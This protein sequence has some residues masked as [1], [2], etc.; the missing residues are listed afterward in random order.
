MSVPASAVAASVARAE[1]TDRTVDVPVRPGQGVPKQQG[2]PTMTKAP[3]T[4]WPE[5]VRAR[6]DLTEAP[7]GDPLAVAP[8]GAVVDTDRKSGAADSAVVAVQ[9]ATA[10]QVVKAGTPPQGEFATSPKET[11]G[12]GALPKTGGPAVRSG[13]RPTRVDVEV[14]DRA[15]VKPVGGV[16]LGLK[17]TRTDGSA[18]PGPVRV[19]VDYSGFRY[20][21]GGDFA[22]RLR[23]VQLPACAL[24]TPRKKGC[25]PD[26]RR[27]VDVDNDER[28]GTLSATVFADADPDAVATEKSGPMLGTYAAT[29]AS[30][31]TVLA[32]TTGSSSDEGD[33]RATTLNPAGSWDVSIGSGA[34]TYEMPFKLPKAPTGSTPSLALTY[35]SQSVDGRTS[36]TNNQASWAG[37]G[38]DLQ[39]G[40]IERRYK[41]CTQDG[42]PT[43]GDMCW[44]S[45]NSGTEPDGAVYVIN[46]NGITSQLIQDGNGTGSYHV[47]DDPGWRV[48]HLWGGHGS[49]DEY[50]VISS[51][52]GMRYYFGWGRSE[53]TDGATDSVLTIPVVGNDTGE[54]CHAQFPEPCAQAWRWNL[55]RVVDPNEVENAYFYDRQTNH[56]RSVANTDKAR[57]YDAGSY[58]TRIEYGWASQITGAQ[59]PAKVEL[60]H[61]G[62]CVERMTEKD[63]LTTEPAACPPIS[64]TPDSY[65]DVPTD[66]MCDGTSGDSYCAGKTYYPTF[67]T[68]DMLWDVKTYVRDNDAAAWDPAMQYQMKYGLPN[69]DGTVGKTL[70]LDYIQRKGYGDGPDLRLPVINFNGEW[71]DNQVGSSLLN[72]RRVTKVYGDLGGVTSVTYGQ[73]DACD[74][75]SLPSQSSNTQPCF[76]QKWTPEGETENRT[77]WFKKYVVT[78]VS[79]DPGVGQGPD[80]DGDPDMTTRYEYNGGAGWRFTNDPLSKDEDETWSDWRGYQQVEVF[81]GTKDN[82]ASTYHWLYRGLD[83]DRTSKT[84]P[85]LTRSVKVKDGFGTEWTDSAWLAGKTLETSKRDG[86]GSSHERVLKEYWVHNTAQYDGLPDARFVRESKTST[87]QRTSTG[88]R[89][90]TVKDEYDSTSSTSTTYG[91][92]LRTNDWGLEDHGDN[93]CTTYGRTYSTAAFPDSDVKRWMVLEDEQRHYAADCADRAAANQ[94]AYTVT[95]YDG[96]TSVTDND[97]KLSDGNPTEKRVHT[98]AA[99]FR[100]TKYEYD[101]AGRVTAAVDGK[102]NRTTTTY[103]PATSW[104]VDGVKVTTPDPD[105]T[106]PGTAMSTT[107]W[108]SRLWGTPYRVV[109][110]NGRSTRIVHDSVGRFSTVFKPTEAANY[111]DG[112]PSVEFTYTLPTTTNADGVPDTVSGPPRI[113][114]AT[115]QSGSTYVTSYEYLD[116]QGRTRETQATAPEGT[117]RTVVST[118]YD[119]SGNV[120][121]TSAAFYNSGAAG[122][123]MVLPTVADLPSYSDPIIDWAGREKEL[124]TLVNGVAQPGGRVRTYYFGDH[125]TVV[126]ATGERTD[127]YTDVFGQITKVVEHGPT[128]PSD[129]SYAYTRSGHLQKITDAKGNTTTYTYNWLGERTATDDPDAGPS[130]SA[131][132]DN[133]QTVTTT[134]ANGAT[135]TYQYDALQ[136]LTAVTEGTTTLSRLTYDSA[137]GGA[138][139]LASATTYADGKAY[140]VAITGYD[141][142]GRMTGKKYTVPDDGSGLTGSYAFGYG[143]DLADHVTSVTYPAAGGLPAETVTTAY[144]AQGQPQKVSSPLATYQS[145]IGFDRL[146]RLNARTFGAGGSDAVVNRA[147]SFDDANGSGALANIKTTVTAGGTTKVAQ[148]DSFTRDLG[149]QIT[150]VR[151][152]VTQQSECFTYDEL[153]RLTRAWTTGA[154]DGCTGAATPDLAGGPDPYDTGYT[155]DELGNLRSVTDRTGS[156]TTTKDYTYPG[157]GADG[158]GYTPNQPRP[159]AVTRAGA[160]TFAYDDAGR[161]TSRTVDG[162][163]STLEWNAQKR[164]SRVTQHKATGDEVSRYV[165]DTEGNVLLRTSAA[166][167]VFYLDGQELHATG[168]TVR[169]TRQYS[170]AGTAVALREADGS[171]GGKLTWLL[172]DTQA[173]TSLLVTMGGIVTRR[174]YSPFGKERGTGGALPAAT[175]RGFLGAPEDDATGLSI[176]GARMYDAELG[177]FISPDE[178][179]QPYVPQQMNAYSYT[180]NNPVNFSD[181]TGLADGRACRCGSRPVLKPNQPA[182]DGGGTPGARGDLGTNVQHGCDQS[183]LNALDSLVN[184]W[185][186]QNINKRLAIELRTYVK[187]LGGNID[188]CIPGADV[189]SGAAA[190]C[191]DKQGYTSDVVWQDVLNEWLSGRGNVLAFGIGSKVT[192]QLATGPHNTRLLQQIRERIVDADYDIA[193]GKLG[194]DAAYVDGQGMG[195]LAEFPKDILGMLTD[196]RQGKGTPDAF[197]GSFNEVYQVLNVDKKNRQFTVGFAAFN[198]TGTASLTHLLPDIGQGNQMASVHQTYYWTVTV[199]E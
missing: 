123:G 71:K 83:G 3:R 116:G 64:T 196:G 12:S 29:T 138:G 162:V 104:P 160:D 137:P 27:F 11:Q 195:K 171:A 77:G 141:G 91:L 20:A 127:T 55:D 56:Y 152:G 99:Q 131:Y 128:G 30:E 101:G 65:P 84:D 86:A 134:N 186:K 153:N 18:A 143:Y 187:I 114:T 34:F 157:Y 103:S 115:L 31:P 161:M 16:G 67:F 69:P 78:E 14:L 92:P 140:T 89:V 96:A 85:S 108:S 192:Q 79:V 177:R 149:G 50:W 15:A 156:G 142:R 36:A 28:S 197:L 194:G 113:T 110:P 191:L 48:Q 88:W 51:Q 68:T 185:Q 19:T 45:P 136:R 130:T 159:H 72:F 168:G 22:S 118:R 174:R 106:G 167:S 41:N 2:E 60:T 23:L 151:D 181:P 158:N 109:N 57:K 133:G 105:G 121:G 173:S 58:L 82:A 10:A 66:L 90:R 169:A 44:D 164:V 112:D 117:G 183:C 35:N 119:T 1:P 13:P 166:E 70:W 80:S 73:P 52:D 63:P 40:Y 4:V 184:T 148:D 54:P 6:V 5:P 199:R 26:R 144:T 47:Q 150:G 9:A 61:V 135:V 93:R 182:P 8:S 176:L 17:V 126:P 155:Y 179:N 59:L 39:T 132:D 170:A 94:D 38:W 87:H 193:A 111:P 189:S 139:Q 190:G 32:V 97:A 122:S 62:R 25:S 76:W 175:D 33:Y 43:I 188:P 145:S 102:G 98:D 198:N 125:T 172:G 129:T 165:Y 42:L 75:N 178:L 163:T 180:A 24:T 95:L 154:Q 146:G 124:Q 46:L 74:I 120:T 147:Y 37:M 53:R 100:S 21:H 81:T 7:A 49:D 107:T